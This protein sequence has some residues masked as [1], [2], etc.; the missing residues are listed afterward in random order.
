MLSRFDTI[1]ERDGRT[2]GQ[3]SDINI[4]R[5]HFCAIKNWKLLALTLARRQAA[6]IIHVKLIIITRVSPLQ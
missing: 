3:N 6:S 5:Q 1:P 4:S 2:D